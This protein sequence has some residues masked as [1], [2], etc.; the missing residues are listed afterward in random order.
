MGG[1]GIM[2]SEFALRLVAT[3]RAEV[4]EVV[5]WGGFVWGGFSFGRV[6]DLPLVMGGRVGRTVAGGFVVGFVSSPSF[7]FEGASFFT[8]SFRAASFC[9]TG[10]RFLVMGAGR[11]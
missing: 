4:A 2:C 6:S 10:S 9:L 7:F 3:D 11:F 5:L 8:G 1:G